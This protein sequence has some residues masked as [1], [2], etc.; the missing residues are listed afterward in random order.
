MTDISPLP[1][2]IAAVILAASGVLLLRIIYDRSQ[3]SALE[4]TALIL[5]GLNPY[6]LGCLS[7]K[8]DAPY[9]AL[10]VMGSIM[11]LYFRRKKMVHIRVC[12]HNRQFGRMYHLPGCDWDFSD[13]CD[14]TRV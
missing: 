13:A 14:R 3:F 11:P 7:Y 6:F 4:L 1:Q 12:V 10:S 9:M 2:M 8:Y 5:F